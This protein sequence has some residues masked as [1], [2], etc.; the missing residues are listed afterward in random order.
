MA[1]KTVQ[2]FDPSVPLDLS[3][4]FDRLAAPHLPTRQILTNLVE[5]GELPRYRGAETQIAVTDT[6]ITVVM[7]WNSLAAA[8]E[9]TDAVLAFVNVDDPERKNM[10]SIEIVQD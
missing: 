7:Q 6:E 4:D 2:I 3:P 9:Y 5:R 1:I 8:Q 10:R